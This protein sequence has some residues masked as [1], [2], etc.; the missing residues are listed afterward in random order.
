MSSNPKKGALDRQARFPRVT[1][2]F[3]TTQN[4]ASISLI[5]PTRGG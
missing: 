5:Y 2:R 3:S 1:Y 4:L